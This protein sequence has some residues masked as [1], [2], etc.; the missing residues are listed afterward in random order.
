MPKFSQVKLAR[1]LRNVILGIIALFAHAHWND[2]WTG[3]ISFIPEQRNQS[4][5][6]LNRQLEDHKLCPDGEPVQHWESWHGDNTTV[7]SLRDVTIALKTGAAVGTE[8]ITIQ[9]RT[10]LSTFPSENMLYIG[11]SLFTANCHIV[12]NVL[13][14]VKASGGGYRAEEE[15]DSFENIESTRGILLS[16]AAMLKLLDVIDTKLCRLNR[17]IRDCPFGDARVSMCLHNAN[18]TFRGYGEY[19]NT[20]TFHP[21]TSITSIQKACQSPITFHKLDAQQML[22]LHEGRLEAFRQGKFYDYGYLYQHFYRMDPLNQR[23]SSLEA[24]TKKERRAIGPIHLNAKT[25]TEFLC[26][27]LCDKDSLCVAWNYWSRIHRCTIMHNL[28]SAKFIRNIEYSTGI[29]VH[30]LQR[31]Y[32]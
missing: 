5:N 25:K 31:Q 20:D 16:R 23:N 11:D 28:D 12:H 24:F 8:R 6:N 7:Q 18:V 19:F 4:S 14:K 17:T 3:F 10:W 15:N 1:S 26:S 13:R 29:P 32:N 21:T 27:R 2:L 9:D 30:C 22:S